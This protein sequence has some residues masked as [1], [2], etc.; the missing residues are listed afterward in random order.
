[1]V[2]VRKDITAKFSSFEHKPIEAL[3]IELNFCKKKW[4]LSFSYNPKKSLNLHSAQYE[5]IVLIGEKCTS[6][7]VKY[8][9][10]L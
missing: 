8:G 7:K 5:N 4:L 3:Y 6:R 10:I 1:M 2:F 9:S